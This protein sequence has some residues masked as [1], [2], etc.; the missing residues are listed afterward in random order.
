MRPEY[1]ACVVVELGAFAPP[2]RPDRL[3]RWAE[4]CH[5]SAQLHREIRSQGYRGSE[6]SV[7][8]FVARWRAS[9]PDGLK[10]ARSGPNSPP[11]KTGVKKIVASARR[12]TNFI[13]QSGAEPEIEMVSVGLMFSSDPYEMLIPASD[14]EFD[15][16]AIDA[17]H[18]QRPKRRCRWRA[19]TGRKSRI[20]LLAAT[21]NSAGSAGLAKCVWKPASSASARS[22]AR[23]NAVSATAGNASCFRL[24][25]I[26]VLSWLKLLSITL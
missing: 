13:R 17:L 18:L 8:H 2:R 11:P 15:D 4:G 24:P 16:G 23:P 3:L 26:R 6:S 1:P 9:L 12:T 19:S 25:P 10:R 22:W 20:K 7:R 21:T 14:P 5:N